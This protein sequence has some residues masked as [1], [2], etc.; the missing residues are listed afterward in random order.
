MLYT[1]LLAGVAVA[2]AT[3]VV[4][5]FRDFTGVHEQVIAV[6]VLMLLVVEIASSR[7][8]RLVDWLL[9]GQRHDPAAASASLSRPLRDVD[10]DAALAALLAALRETLRLTSASVVLAGRE[11]PSAAPDATESRFPIRRAGRD[12]GELRAGRRGQPLDRRDERLLEAA[13][14]QIGLVLH[15]QDLSRETRTAQEALVTGV[16]EERRRLRREIHDGVG[17]TL[18]GIALGVESAQ[19]ALDGDP[20]RA[21]RLLADVR[22]DVD[23]LLDEVRHLVDGLRPA[24]LDELGLG[25]ALRAL[26]DG[27]ARRTSCTVVVEE[28]LPTTLPA[29]VEVAAYRIGAE[30]LANVAKHAGAR[31]V[32]L[33]ARATSSDLVLVV[34]DDGRGGAEPRTGGTGLGSML[35]RA[36]ELGGVLEVVSGDG[37]TAVTARLP[38]G[39]SR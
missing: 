37:G 3:L 2:M 39:T 23:E 24:M 33:V 13:A 8:H 9:Y 5:P 27:F 32:R 10:D 15:A 38:V 7:L 1:L 21:A 19:R 28:A 29:A 16:E 30:A 20:D 26:A 12:L 35:Q 18:A 17:P 4:P 25:G 36:E 11:N 31:R 14:A 34:D 22:T 6:A